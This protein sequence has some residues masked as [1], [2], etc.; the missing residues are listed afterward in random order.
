MLLDTNRLIQ[1]IR[2]DSALP[3]QLLRSVVVVAELEAF[4]LKL[5][6]G[7]RRQQFLQTMRK[8]FPL[9]EITELLLPAYAFL[10]VYSQGKLR[11]DTPAAR[12]VGAQHGQK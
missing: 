2:Y 11:A 7:T 4:S 1:H 5:A 3:A 6:W 9:I 10:A 8:R 12:P